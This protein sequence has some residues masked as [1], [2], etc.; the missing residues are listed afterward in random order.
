MLNLYLNFNYLPF[1]FTLSFH[2]LNSLFLIHITFKAI[3]SEKLFKSMSFHS[4]HI[5]FLHYKKKKNRRRNFLNLQPLNLQTYLLVCPF[6]L[7]CFMDQG[8]VLMGHTI[9]CPPLIHTCL[10]LL[11]YMLSFYSQTPCKNCLGSL[12]VLPLVIIQSL[13]FGFGYS[14][15]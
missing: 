6:F 9:V 10:H 4:Q 15:S 7:H 13:K 14:T 11:L 8:R 1:I 12:Y 5:S 2:V 3:D